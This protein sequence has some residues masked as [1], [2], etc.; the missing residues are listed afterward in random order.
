MNSSD[1]YKDLQYVYLT[2]Q[3]IVN[4]TSSVKIYF[5]NYGAGYVGTGT[6]ALKN[7]FCKCLKEN[8][9]GEKGIY[10]HLC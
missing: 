9:L 3:G 10:G 4:R 2:I 7:L 6:W 8:I 1:T 5:N